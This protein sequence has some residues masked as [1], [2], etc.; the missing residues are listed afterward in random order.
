MAQ[1]KTD[2]AAITE[3]PKK[4]NKSFIIVLALMIIVGGGYGIMKYLHAQHHEETDDAQIQANIS[5]VIPRI[6]GYVKEVK[7]KDNQ[8]VKKG[9]TLLILDERDLALRVQQAEAALAI[10]YSNLSAAEANTSASKA[11]ISSVKSGMSTADAQIEAAKITL[12][13]TTQD[14]NRYQNL[15][16]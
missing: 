3:A 1:Y 11:N 9:D 16:F 13:R 10:A 14:F 5:P 12:W 8:R 15:I 7:V 4:K 2:E 6:G